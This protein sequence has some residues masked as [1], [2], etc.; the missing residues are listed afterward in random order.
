[1]IDEKTLRNMERYGGSFVKALAHLYKCAD[2][3]NKKKLEKVFKEYFEE[4]KNWPPGGGRMS[5]VVEVRA[6]CTVCEHFY[7]DWKTGEMV[8]EIHGKV[9]GLHW[10]C[11]CDRFELW[12]KLKPKEVEE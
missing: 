8:C 7:I 2:P 4:Y 5:R 9:P 3:F 10:L 11:V 1:M 12:D 6:C